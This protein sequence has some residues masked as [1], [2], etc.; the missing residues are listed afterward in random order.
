[1]KRRAVVPL[2]ILIAAAAT[3]GIITS[4]HHDGFS[5]Y[6]SAVSNYDILDSTPYKKDPMRALADECKRQGIKFAFYYS[7]I[8]WHHPSQYVDAPE[9]DPTAGDHQTKMREG[10]KPAYVSYMKAQL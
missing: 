10:Q 9:K 6:D 2:L 8:D 4:K 3:A 7:I 1:M 5:M